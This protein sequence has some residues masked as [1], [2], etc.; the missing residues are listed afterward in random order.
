M[1]HLFTIDYSIITIIY[2]R[3]N[4]AR[5]KNGKGERMGNNAVSVSRRKFSKYALL[6]GAVLILP[7]S[8]RSKALANE[9]EQKTRTTDDANREV[10]VSISPQRV[11]PSGQYAE[12]V[13]KTLCPEK[14]ISTPSAQGST[15]V[16]HGAPET[17]QLFVPE[18]GSS[19][20][21]ASTIIELIPDLIIDVGDY[22]DGLELQLN[23]LEAQT[24]TPTLYVDAS[25][26]NLA[27]AYRA[28]GALLDCAERAEQL[29]CYIE[30]TSN[31]ISSIQSGIIDRKRVLFCEGPDGLSVRGAQSYQAQAIKKIGA[32]SAAQYD[33]EA[34]SI[35]VDHADIA[36]WNPDII[37]FASGSCYEA[38]AS[39]EVR[40]GAWRIVPAITSGRFFSVPFRQYSWFGSPPLLAQSLG[41]LWLGNLLYPDAYVFDIAEE[42]RAFY[43]LFFNVDISPSEAAVLTEIKP[44]MHSAAAN[45]DA[46]P[47]AIAASSRVFRV[48]MDSNGT[49]VGEIEEAQ[50]AAE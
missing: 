17:G 4:F 26:D 5:N 23:N 31:R 28:L 44:M 48:I 49:V 35:D 15:P 29:A 25:F 12:A 24:N 39:D 2:A 34:N 30:D 21:D 38:L 47:T 18:E 42:A 43:R 27:S 16:L 6:T 33:A 50:E 32:I 14:L 45:Q 9:A 46:A 3:N 40:W 36:D 37:L 41:M 11:V 10:I 19:S 1:L 8:L 22:K 20:I 7:T 13:L